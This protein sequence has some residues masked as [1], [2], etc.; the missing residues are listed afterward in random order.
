MANMENQAAGEARA[1]I[2]SSL[3]LSEGTIKR[4]VVVSR[5]HISEQTFSREY[6]SFLD[7][8]P[9]IHYDQKTREFSY[10]P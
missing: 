3:V 4:G 9:N 1:K 8:Y 2:F 10:V 6:M 5:L 7:Q